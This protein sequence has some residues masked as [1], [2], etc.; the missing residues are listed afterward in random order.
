MNTEIH[1]WTTQSPDWWY[2]AVF[3]HILV[4]R[5]RRGGNQPLLGDPTNPVFC[6]GD[7]VGV[8]ESLDYLRDLGITA[9]WLSPINSTAAYHGYHITNYEDVDKRFG[10]MAAFNALIKAAKPDIK[11]VLDWVPNHV[12]RTHPFFQ[13]A[14]ASN[15]SRFRDWFS[16]D[17]HGNH[18]CFLGFTELPKLNLDHPEARKYMITTALHWIDLGVDGFR[19]DH[20]VGPSLG[21]WREF[22]DAVKRH[23]PSTFLL[24]EAT[25]MGVRYKDLKTLKIP[26]KHWHWLRS[27]LRI[28]ICAGV[29][30]EYAQILDGLLD[31]EFQRIVKTHVAHPTH[32]PS[33]KN[34]QARLNAHYAKFPANCVLPAFLDNHDM[35]R[36]LYEAKSKK[37][38]LRLGAQ[39]QFQQRHPPVIYYGTEVGLNQS[40]SI[41][42]PHGDL[43]AR[44][45]M[46]WKN[47]DKELFGFFRDLIHRRKESARSHLFSGEAD[48]GICVNTLS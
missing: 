35:N 29:M 28:P 9:L 12:H 23:S 2:D 15:R 30:R 36:F 19:L 39:L 32:K 4:D 43:A 47:Q 17:V 18:L 21:F 40:H 14:A 1:K 16:F 7:L 20:L 6:G 3:Y 48:D 45:M 44:Q 33:L 8:V 13:Q 5:F 24:G 41:V 38:R 42:G 27:Q 22:Q 11:I 26:R 46:P 34:A 37:E 31:F 25:M 10:G